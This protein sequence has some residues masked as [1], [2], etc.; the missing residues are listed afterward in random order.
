M[1]HR[2]GSKTSEQATQPLDVDAARSAAAFR[3]YLQQYELHPLDVA[4]TS[5]VRYL[6]VWNLMKG[7]P[8]NADHA[9]RVRFG[10]YTM[11]SVLYTAPILLLA[12]QA[13]LIREDGGKRVSSRRI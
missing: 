13:T 2:P 1:Q 3:A 6:S 11:T 12:E 7:K 5:K 4:I 9:A 8:I 10:L